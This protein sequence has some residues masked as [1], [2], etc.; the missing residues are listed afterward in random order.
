MYVIRYL[1]RSCF[2]LD[3]QGFGR[4]YVASFMQHEVIGPA[5]RELGASLYQ[6]DMLTEVL[7]IR[8]HGMHN[9]ASGGD[10]A[11]RSRSAAR[12]V[13]LLRRNGEARVPPM[14]LFASCG[15]PAE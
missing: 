8:G 12:A 10:R 1:R 6:E 15:K 5:R 7:D 13:Q 11:R 9:P 4:T 2:R 3:F 14:G